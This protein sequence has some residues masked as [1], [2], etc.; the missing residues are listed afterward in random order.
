MRVN[1]I[2]S[3]LTRQLGPMERQAEIARSLF[4]EK[5][6]AEDATMSICFCWIMS[7]SQRR[8]EET[9]EKQA[10]AQEELEETKERY[11][12]AKTEY[13]QLEAELEALTQTLQE[14]RDS[15][16]SGQLK[17]QQFE[18]QV[19]L[20]QEQINTARASDTHLKAR[21]EGN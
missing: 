5:R 8:L 14:K 7:G 19:Q 4:K 12:K 1:D 18:S 15:V 3:E 21:I 13:E 10:Q 17:K 16:T 6:R 9:G 20:L 11:E 2:L